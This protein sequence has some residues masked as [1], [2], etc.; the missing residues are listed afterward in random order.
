MYIRFISK[1]TYDEHGIPLKEGW[2]FDGEDQATRYGPYKTKEIAERAL[3]R[4]GDDLNK[5]DSQRMDA[6][7]E[8][9]YPSDLD[10]N[11]VNRN[12]IKVLMKRRNHLSSRTAENPRLTYDITERK[13][14]DWA[15]RVLEET[16]SDRERTE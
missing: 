13:A 15:I 9:L 16:L 5:R 10:N 6:E 14:L 7:D 1:P 8:Q 11:S 2:Y 12:N 3:I 4:Y